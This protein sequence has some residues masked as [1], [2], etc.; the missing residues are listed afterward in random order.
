MTKNVRDHCPENGGDVYRDRET[1]PTSRAERQGVDPGTRRAR[2]H[3]HRNYAPQDASRPDEDHATP[4]EPENEAPGG[5]PCEASTTRQLQRVAEA[6][7][8]N[9]E[10][11]ARGK[12]Q[13]R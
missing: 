11:E 2:S 1:G 9:D 8:G 4:P 10:E 6:G 13:L 7:S 5:T 12:R 3:D